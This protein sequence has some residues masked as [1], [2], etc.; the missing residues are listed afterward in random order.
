MK[1]GQILI[2]KTELSQ[3]LDQAL[4]IKAEMIVLLR[5]LEEKASGASIKKTGQWRQDPIKW[6]NSHA[7][8]Y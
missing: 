5:E 2:P 4:Q 7:S 3:K 8:E 1:R 6:L